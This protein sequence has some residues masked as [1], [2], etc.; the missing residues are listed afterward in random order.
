MW[1]NDQLNAINAPV[2]D[3]LVT[4]AAGSGK[5]AVMV[6]RI[7]QRVISD[8]GT[9]IDRMLVVTFTK[10]AASEIKERIS[11]KIS[12]TLLDGGSERLKNQLV[13]INRASICT[14]HSFC[15]DIIKNNFHLLGLDPNFKIADTTDISVLKARALGDVLDEYY[16]NE[17]DKDFYRIINSFTKKNDSAIEKII[18]DVYNFSQSMA[19]PYGWLDK[20]EKVYSGDCNEAL[21]YILK[22]V[23]SDAQYCSN[24]YKKAIKLCAFDTS[25]EL[26][27]EVLADELYIC[28]GICKACD[29]GWDKV[30]NFVKNY[31]FR[32]LS[33]RKSMDASVFEEIKEIRGKARKILKDIIT[34][35]VNLPLSVIVEDLVYM[36][37]CV[38]KICELVRAFDKRYTQY[39]RD[40]NLVDFNDFEHL[41]LKL[42]TDDKYSEVSTAI[43]D[44]YDEI[45]VDEYQDC[46]GVQEAIFKAVSREK[47][48]TPNMFMVG[49]IKQCIYRFR[50]AE[51]QLFKNKSDTYTPYNGEVNTFNKIVLNKNFRSRKEILDGVN[52]IFS[53]VM[54]ENVG[55]IDY[56]DSEYLY[57]GAEYE[58]T[59]DDVS[60]IDVDI[61]D[62]ASYSGFESDGFDDDEK[63][64][65]VE[66]ESRFV[67]DKIHRM[68]KS[69]SYTVFDKGAKIY[70]PLK[71]RDIVILL[72]SANA[73]AEYFADALS[74]Y[75]IPSFTDVGGGYFESEEVTFILN[76]L[77][78][79]S[80]PMDDIRL[81]SVMRSAVFRFSDN[82]LLKIR[83]KHREGY[84]YIAIQKYLDVG[85]ALS[86]KLKNFVKTL[87]KYREQSCIMD[88]DE[89]LRYIIADTDYIDYIGTLASPALKKAN[90]RMLLNK[91][92]QFVLAEGGTPVSFA[93]FVDRQISFGGSGGD[94]VK[95]IGEND[96]VVRIMTIHKSKGLEF[97]VVF[98]SM[99][100]K[101]FNTRDVSD[102]VIMH[103][104]LGIGINYVDEKKRFLYKPTVK[105]AVASKILEESI[106]EEM[107]LLYVALTRAREKLV[108]SGVT[109]NFWKLDENIRI[110]CTD[111]EKPDAKAVSQCRTYMEWILCALY[112][113][114][115]E[116]IIKADSVSFRRNVISVH[117]LN[118]VYA[119]GVT[120]LRSIP[121][122]DNNSSFSGEIYRRLEYKYPYEKLSYLP[123]NVTVTEIKRL[124]ETVDSSAYRMYKMPILQQPRFLSKGESYSAAQIG[125][126]MHHCMQK[127][128][129]TTVKNG[130]TIKAEIE[131]LVKSGA[132][133]EGEADCVD[134][135]AIEKFFLSHVGQSMLNAAFVRREVPFEIF[136]KASELFPDVSTDEKIVVQGMIDAYFEDSEGNIVLVDYKTDRRKGRTAE[137]FVDIICER[138]SLQLKYYEKALEL[139]TGRSVFK[140]YIYLFDTGNTVEIKR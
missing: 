75:S 70:R 36:L 38:S 113:G 137:E 23:K 130:G 60:F 26:C 48:G 107:R 16:E 106:S 118:S 104:A 136:V 115:N 12:K 129:L 122:K 66:A 44:K 4:A 5:T 47:S 18:S 83:S 64:A 108:V 41:A 135:S 98:L 43:R 28:E 97:P 86:S 31:S 90:I 62:M 68:V 3:I 63:P 85:D 134:V 100:G 34:N 96:D 105:N 123:R 49:D 54:S 59:N 77:K 53:S 132:L 58:N 22:E 21:S 15:L 25:F 88:A 93:R 40:K 99:C 8:N 102:A 20:C 76:I 67:A 125:T 61:I 92:H 126:I 27:K 6:E 9:D 101:K 84:F 55:E 94:S 112:N 19:D 14:I 30:Y 32:K 11:A 51:P 78:I 10:A 128:E 89:F 140:K 71:Y 138:Y 7:I 119:D 1:T 57:Q 133:T 39:K 139:L 24:L 50:K 46:N 72:R 13:L 79:V 35:K 131:K 80:N 95:I 56:T 81:V 111:G 120:D 45:Y 33:S 37:P 116:G 82:E 42:L 2:A 121:D 110:M 124:N 29:D 74:D 127:I 65:K 87:E 103:N 17:D 69:G 91:A 117:E 73:N 114:S 52:K 109:D